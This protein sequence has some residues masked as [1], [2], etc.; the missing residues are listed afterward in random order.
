MGK[1]LLEKM[2]RLMARC[3]LWKYHP[4]VVGITG[5]VGKSSTK[6]AIALVLARGFFVRAADGNYNNE[7]GIPLTIIGAKSGGR[8]PLRWIGVLCR[9]VSLMVLP[10]RYPEILVLEMGVDHPGDMEYLLGFIP[11]RVGVTTQVSGSH[12]AN[13]GSIA[14]IAKEKGGLIAALP[15]DGFAILNADDVRVAKMSEKTKAKV[16][17]YGFGAADVRADNIIFYGEARRVEGFSF[18]LDFEGKSVPVRLPKIVAR[19]HIPAALAAV[20]VGLA[21]RMHLVDIASALETFEPLPGRLRLL[22]GRNDMTLIDDTYNA[23]PVSMR[24][25]LEV[26][27]ELSAPRKIAVLGDMLELGPETEQEHAALA[28]AVAGSGANLA[29]LV[30]RHMRSLH[31]ALLEGGYA[32]KQLLWMPDP[33]AASEALLRIVRPEDLILVKGSRGMRMEKVTEALFVDPAE[34]RNFLCCQSPEWRSRPFMPPA[35]WTV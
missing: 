4:T 25:A 12:L 26:L 16:I 27:G 5:S 8:S 19:H 1:R 13:F 22:P 30:G 33:L 2:L 17:T 35:E 20:A 32:R 24:A 28:D 11:V 14:G 15:E 21:F 7:I 29:I 3:I 23:S 9:F 31:D 18:K 6:E 10:L 34:T